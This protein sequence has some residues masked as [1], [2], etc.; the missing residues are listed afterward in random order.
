MQEEFL[1]GDFVL[2][3]WPEVQELM[4]FPWFR[5]EC[6]LMQGFPDQVHY[7][8]SYFVPKKRI[9]EIDWEEVLHYVEEDVHL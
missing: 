6:Y 7:D 2:V 5:K 3:L 9:E 4:R 1:K 8:S